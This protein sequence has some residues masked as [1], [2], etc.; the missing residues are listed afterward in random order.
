MKSEDPIARAICERFGDFAIDETIADA[1]DGLE[2]IVSRRSHRRFAE[3]E[4]SPG[5]MQTLFACAFSAPSKSDLQ[6]AS[7]VWLR[8]RQQRLAVEALMPSMPWI[9]KAPE[10]LVFCGD[11][12]RIRKI[13]ALR[14]R[15]FAN[16]HL[17]SFFNATVDGTLVLMS[18][19]RAAEAVG[20]GCCPLSVIRNEASALAKV[21]ELPQHVFPIAGLALGYPSDAGHV[22]ARLGL[23]AT[24]HVDRYD[25]AHFHDNLVEY[26]TRRR[27]REPISDDKQ[28]EQARFGIAKEYTWSEDKARQVS[29]R[30]RADFGAFVRAQGFKLD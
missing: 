2:T 8:D 16:D 25:D 4:I 28:R 18:F 19:I 12:A 10:L 20:L 15:P 5:V 7:V 27:A 21:L 11:N 13:S 3:R 9:A 26:D 17:D 29:V 23:T 14:E 1:R 24:V 6:Q 22:S 30:E